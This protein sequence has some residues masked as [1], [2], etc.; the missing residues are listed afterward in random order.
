[1]RNIHGVTYPKGDAV[2][3]FVIKGSALSRG[4]NTGLENLAWG[5]ARHGWRI[6]VM[7]GGN[8]PTSHIYDLPE[9]I[10][11]HFI[12]REG[13]PGNHLEA[14]RSLAERQMPDVVIG[15]ARF[16]LLIAKTRGPGNA[17]PLLIVNEGA[18]QDRPLRRSGPRGLVRTVRSE[19]RR[20]QSRRAGI[21]HVV[22]ISTAVADNVREIY[23]FA[24]EKLNIIGRGIDTEFYTPPKHRVC[25]PGPGGPMRLLYTGNI[26]AA[27]GLGTVIAA[28]DHIAAPVELRLCGADQDGYLDRLRANMPADRPHRLVFRNRLPPNEVRAELQAADAFV[29]PSRSEGLGKSLLEAMASGLPAVVSDLPAFRDVVIDGVNALVAPADDAPAFANAII[30]LIDD[31]ELRKVLGQ[32]AHQTICTKFSKELEIEKWHELLL[33]KTRHTLPR[34][35]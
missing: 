25:A 3:L 11:Y 20:W 10:E 27:K 8:A 28:L 7:A 31:P 30:R 5:L 17:C 9:G 24:P 21:D 14:Y 4:M 19:I 35:E 29:F 12:G 1:M 13:T 34:M 22:A 2:I 32:N 33:S 26:V 15:W 6:K 23:D 18:M 16:L